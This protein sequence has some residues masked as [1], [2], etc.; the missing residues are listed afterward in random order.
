MVRP[1]PDIE[2]LVTTR[3]PLL[4][5]GLA[6]AL[7]GRDAV[8]QDEA[9]TQV[10]AVYGDSMAQ[11]VGHMLNQSL[12]RDRRFRVVNRG[13]PATALGQPANHNW[14]EAVRN[15]VRQDHPGYSVMMFGGNDR[16]AMRPTG[17]GPYIPFRS[18]AWVALYRERL[19]A[20]L[21][22][23]AEAQVRIVWVGY[24]I[25]RE[26][27]YSGDMA[28]L[29]GIYREAV[30]AR[31]QDFIDTWTMFADEQGRFTPDRRTAQGRVTRLRTEDGIH[32][33]AAGYD[34]IAQRVK[35]KIEEL[36][37]ARAP[38]PAPAPAEPPAEGQAR[39]GGGSDG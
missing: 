39:A 30:E 3:R 5:A 28:F 33:T 38:A 11:G 34:M 37:A 18:D 8:A 32:L 22:P 24:P 29:N 10:V 4:L 14:I 1:R 25:A 13:K 12:L 26:P 16:L 7:G 20:M 27:R 21:Q 6:A 2:R 19:D 9:P 31:G 15:S 17:G 35:T 36:H 23:L